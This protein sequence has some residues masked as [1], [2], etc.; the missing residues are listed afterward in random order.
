MNQ[1]YNTKCLHQK[2]LERLHIDNL[3]THLKFLEE[4]TQYYTKRIDGKNKLRA[5]IIEI[6]TN[7]KL[8]KIN[9]TKS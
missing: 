6:Q 5:E 1:V 8:Q 3:T 4:E 7:K 2:N 9:K